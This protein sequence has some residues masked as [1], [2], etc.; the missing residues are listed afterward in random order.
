L[1]CDGAMFDLR[2]FEKLRVV[3]IGKAAHAMVDGLALVLTPFVR[4][5]GVV[6]APTPARRPLPGVK[7]FVAGHPM[8]NEESWKAA[9][10]ILAL[11]RGI[12]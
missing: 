9:E 11:L 7:Y 6:S 10:A 1:H 5:E 4:F 2:N 12:G 8:P 3:A